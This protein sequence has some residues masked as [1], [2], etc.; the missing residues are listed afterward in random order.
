MP[1][2]SSYLHF[3]MVPADS[4]QCPLHS[5][6]QCNPSCKHTSMH[7]LHQHRFLH[8]CMDCCCIRYNLPH[9]DFLYS[10]AGKCRKTHSLDQCMCCYGDKGGQRSHQHQSHTTFP[11]NQANSGNGSQRQGL[12]NWRHF[13]MGYHDN[14]RHL[15]HKLFQ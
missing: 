14:H 5:S 4:H 12:D 3:D 10:Q 6:S 9:T 8:S 7:S 1:K 2:L 15:S 11:Q 13:Y